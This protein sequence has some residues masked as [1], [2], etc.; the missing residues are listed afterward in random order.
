MASNVENRRGFP[1]AFGFLDAEIVER[2]S[3]DVRAL[4]MTPGIQRLGCNRSLA[5]AELGHWFSQQAQHI[6][7]RRAHTVRTKPDPPDAA[8]PDRCRAR[9]SHRRRETSEAT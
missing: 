6:R 1:S 3:F 5:D 8:A 2:D 7:A 9:S 4:L